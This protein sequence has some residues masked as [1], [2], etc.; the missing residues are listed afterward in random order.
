MS[1]D[2]FPL[3]DV[4][5]IIRLVGPTSFQR[6]RPYARVGAVIDVTWDSD[7]GSLTGLVQGTKPRP[8]SCNI[9]LAPS[10]SALRRPLYG[11]C[12][13]PMGQDCKHVAATLIEANSIYIQE[14]DDARIFHASALRG[15]SR[16]HPARAM[17]VRAAAPEKTKPT[18]RWKSALDAGNPATA[19]G[20]ASAAGSFAPNS[21]N[22]SAASVPM[23]LLFELRETAVRRGQNWGAAATKA[24][25][26]TDPSPAARKKRRLAVRPVTKSPTGNWVRGSLTWYSLSF[27]T[28][29][30]GLDPVQ[31]LW[32]A[33][34]AGLYSA[35]NPTHFG[36]SPEWLLLEDFHS[37]LFWNLMGQAAELGIAF[38]GPKKSASV[39]LGSSVELTLDASTGGE[40]ATKRTAAPLQLRT[41][42]RIDGTAR[43]ID[44]AGTIGDHGVY[45]I[46]TT[47]HF[48][49]TVAPTA[50]PLSSDQRALFGRA[51]QI[52][53][54]G[55]DVP[56]F[57]TEYYPRL[58]RTIAITSDD[59]SVRLPEFVP[60]VLVLSA[61]FLPENG[62]DLRWNW[63]YRIGDAAS[64]AQTK[65]LRPGDD[66]S[67]ARDTAVERD[68]LRRVEA[69]L[70]AWPRLRDTTSTTNASTSSTGSTASTASTRV[71]DQVGALHPVATLRGLAAAQ[72]SHDVLPALEALDG[73]R[74]EISGDR[75]AYQELTAAPT[76][77]VRTEATDHGDWFDLGVTVTI[78]GRDVPFEPLFA[79]LSTNQDTLLLDDDSFL[80]LDQPVFDSLKKLIDEASTL[81]DGSATPRIS[82]YQSSLW[83]ELTELA[84]NTE[85]A[86]TWRASV[87]GLL[88]LQS[89]PPVP[90]PEQIDATLRP[91]QHDGFTWLA[92]LWQHQL[93][94]V[95]ADD[96]GLGKT[97]QTL[98]LIS[99]AVNSSG[100]R[101]VAA[102][103]FLVIAPTSVVS[104]WVS[105][106]ERFAPHLA[107]RGITTTQAKGRVPLDE[108][109][110]GT[111]LVITSYALFRLDF[112]AY[113]NQEWAGMILDEAQFVK[114]P[115]SHTHRCAVELRAPFKLAITGTPMENSLTDLW[116]LFSIVAPGLFPS[117]RGFTEEYVRPIARGDN[118]DLVAR[119]RR[120]IRP[121]MMRRTKDLVAADLPAKQEQVLK[122]DLAPKHKKLYDTYLQRERK[123]LLGL[124]DDFDKNRF[125]VFRSL[126]LL[127]ML[128]LDASLVDDKYS[129]IPSSKLDSLFEQ[130]E[131]V[132]AEDHRALI[133]SQFTS[134]LKKAAARLD[135]AGIEYCYLDGSTMNRGDVIK[136]FKEGTAPVFL[137]SLKAGGF[138]LNL[139]EADYVFLLDPW[140][141]PASESQ[142]VDRT[143]RIGQS[144]SVMVYRM[145]ST[146]TIEEK[147]MALKEKKSRL[148]DAVMDDDAVFSSALTAD[149]IRGLLD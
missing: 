63:E 77:T 112:E 98:A 3:V 22:T 120:R 31:R 143:H 108:L 14:A 71:L 37:P 36:P 105:E 130:L 89:V 46:E 129:D 97:L 88:E 62:L 122:I 114:N 53:V 131:D 121:L 138:G 83:S 75:P 13:C 118:A 111:N 148:F 110:A 123:K 128:S 134:F 54:P 23:A 141:N 17:E 100:Q 101:D 69:A 21:P 93:G 50:Q 11:T 81:Q 27:P 10:G 5:D 79:A 124:M 8:Y 109:V 85:Q 47:P 92:F 44:T 48:A 61:A 18:P 137:I 58:R 68:V 126:T 28:N 102:P 30:L 38:V 42:L 66:E 132:V 127:R 144:K 65:T 43:P 9:Q 57:L 116:S 20:S 145:I 16:G 4:G 67:G 91:Y 133:F 40:Q 32:F 35:T 147:V 82:R 80:S 39:Q 1:F 24:A 74:I 87:S 52:S 140:W 117:L 73:V 107:V 56:E 70:A 29:Q 34:L 51:D 6:G 76:L 135:A 113:Q 94:G 45:S 19:P 96:M 60:P 72:F 26:L 136:R 99:H 15:A 115:T 84:D 119:L 78:E 12:T 55:K 149:D 90:V 95:L 125:Q 41:R 49:V 7:T 86:D 59:A 103:P 106:A 146:G 2:A 104:N 33:Q 139:T 142:A 64:V 25:T